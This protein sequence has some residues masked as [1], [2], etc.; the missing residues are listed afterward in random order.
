MLLFVSFSVLVDTAQCLSTAR[1]HMYSKTL[2][3][4]VEILEAEDDE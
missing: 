2:L 1:A 3:S 4:A